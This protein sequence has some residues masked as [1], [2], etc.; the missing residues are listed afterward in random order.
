MEKTCLDLKLKSNVCTKCLQHPEVLLKLSK[1]LCHTDVHSSLFPKLGMLW[2]SLLGI[3]PWPLSQRLLMCAGRCE[4][5]SEGAGFISLWHMQLSAFIWSNLQP[6]AFTPDPQL[7]KLH[8]CTVQDMQG[9]GGL[10]G[11]NP[12]KP[13]LLEQL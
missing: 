2:G 5:L 4:P 1:R 12:M 9:C 10:S 3:L 6:A 8:H 13:L 7:E 11:E